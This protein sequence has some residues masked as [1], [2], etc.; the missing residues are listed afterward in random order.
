MQLLTSKRPAPEE[1]MRGR[2]PAARSR[3]L[4]ERLLEQAIRLIAVSCVLI[5]FLIFVFVFKEAAP[6]LSGQLRTAHEVVD[7][8]LGEMETY[9]DD[10][11]GSV[12][13]SPVAGADPASGPDERLDAKHLL[14]AEWKP[15]SLTPRYGL[16][17]LVAGTLKVTFVALCIAVPVGVFAA[18]YTAAFAPKWA[19]EIM[20]PAIEILAGIPSVVIG[21]FAL[22]IL[23]TLLQDLFGTHYRLNAFVGGVA[24]SLAVI[25]IIYTISEDALAS[26]PRSLT[27]AGLALGAT[28]FEAAWSIVLPAALPG[29]VAAALLGFGRA[30]GETMIVLMATG[31]AA[32]LSPV[33]TEPVRTLS[34]TIGAEMAEVVFGDV[35]YR[36]LFFL[37]AL[38]FA[39]SFAVNALAELFVRGYLAKRFR[40]AAS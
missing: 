10:A 19:K 31:N 6:V 37:G 9:E 3:R 15:T 32:L 30:F 20:K 34:A 29:I 18:L 1:A 13:G 35:H 22:V 36:V 21:F 7:E 16:L 26:V 27:E 14:G 33:L 5:I 38:L 25:P 39:V 11:T 28:R 24:L 2:S 4:G 17:P 8:G 12:A 40:G 23:A